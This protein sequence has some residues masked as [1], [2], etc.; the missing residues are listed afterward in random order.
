MHRLVHASAN[1]CTRKADA[2]NWARQTRGQARCKLSD[3]STGLGRPP[4]EAKHETDQ[5]EDMS[6][7]Y[8]CLLI[9]NYIY[10]YIIIYI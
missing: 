10:N 9:Y 3:A 5:G 6:S 2:S 8:T 7:L 1:P 4:A